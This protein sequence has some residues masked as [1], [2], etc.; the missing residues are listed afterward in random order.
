[1]GNIGDFVLPAAAT[2]DGLNAGKIVV[3]STAG[4]K[5][6]NITGVYGS[7]SQLHLRG[8]TPHRV[9]VANDLLAYLLGKSWYSRDQAH[10]WMPKQATVRLGGP[11]TTSQR[12]YL[13]GYC[14]AGQLEKGPLPLNVQ[15]D[16]KALPP[17]R[18]QPGTER[19]DFSFELPA[20]LVG[21]PS[22]E[23]AVEVGR[24]FKPP[25]EER[26]LGLAFGVFEIR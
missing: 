22:V 11:K 16:G 15:V 4:D 8:E 24:T 14:P 17:V 10:R 5:L 20:G 2:L 25:G 19:F 26:E 3:Y 7:T 9:D 18:I 13:S 12:L 1:L 6:K 23:V 21:K